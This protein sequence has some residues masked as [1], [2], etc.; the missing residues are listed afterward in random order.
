MFNSE[1]D[2]FFT[3]RSAVNSLI[4]FVDSSSSL[5]IFSFYSFS[6]WIFSSGV[7]SI[8]SGF[9]LPPFFF[10]LFPSTFSGYDDFGYSSS[11]FSSLFLS[12]YS[13]RF[14]ISVSALTLSFARDSL[15]PFISDNYFSDESFN[16]F[17]AIS[18]YSL[19]IFIS[20]IQLFSYWV[21]S[22]IYASNFVIYSVNFLLISFDSALSFSS[23]ETFS[24]SLSLNSEISYS[25][26]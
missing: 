18:I 19:S 26:I 15:R 22:A 6:Y 14:L 24:F 12:N 23:A 21:F 3:S 4:F 20:S 13:L 10:F 16:Y 8:T 17:E 1:T 7:N 9:Y 11:T 25:F 5:V 2:L